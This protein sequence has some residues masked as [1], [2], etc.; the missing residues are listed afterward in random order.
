VVR[1]IDTDVFM[2]TMTRREFREA[3]DEG[4]VRLVIVPTGSCEQHGDHLM[5]IHDTATVFHLAVRAAERLKPWVKVAPPIPFG[6]SEYWMSPEFRAG[7]ITLRF[8]HFAAVLSDVLGSLRRQG[9]RNLMVLNGHGGNAR[10]VSS[11]FLEELQRNLDVK[12][13]FLS[14][15]DVLSDIPVTDLMA[16]GKIPGHAGEFETSIALYLFPEAVRLSEVAEEEDK[17]A[18]CEK[19]GRLVEAIVEG[20]VSRIRMEFGLQS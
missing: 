14:Y 10:P 11:P 18:T 2:Y 3:V 19:G 7:T 9:V 1:C 16:K 6:Y 8:E 13:V 15:W 4:T 20:V 12:I 5:L 17:A